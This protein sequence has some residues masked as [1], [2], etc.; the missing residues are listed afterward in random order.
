MQLEIKVGAEQN[1]PQMGSEGLQHLEVPV[2]AHR[3]ELVGVELLSRDLVLDRHG[4][5]DLLA[6]EEHQLG[7]GA[8][9]GEALQV[10]VPARVPP[11]A[12][13]RGLREG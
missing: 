1:G 3:D 11:W 5:L 8:G 13:A 6:E 7:V 2:V 10:G 4:V 12:V 9:Q